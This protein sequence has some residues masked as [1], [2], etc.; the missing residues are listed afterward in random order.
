MDVQMPEMDGEQCTIEIRKQLPSAQQPRIIAVTANA[1][2][3]DRDRYLSIGMDD[4]IV[5][6][7]KI[8]ELV[9]AL[10]ESYIYSK[11]SKKDKRSEREQIR[12][13]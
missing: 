6:P 10:V 8:E 11:Q 2:T 7:F 13:F 1:L 9:R 5:K 3:T 4:Y 12:H